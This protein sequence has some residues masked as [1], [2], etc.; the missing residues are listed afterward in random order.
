MV[1]SWWVHDVSVVGP[2]SLRGASVHGKNVQTT[3]KPKW[4]V[5]INKTNSV[6]RRLIVALVPL[7]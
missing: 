6:L 2:W 5:H 4:C 7:F 3:M 1:L